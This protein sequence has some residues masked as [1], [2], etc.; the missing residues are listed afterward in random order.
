VQFFEPSQ[1]P[2]NPIMIAAAAF[3]ATP[4]AGGLRCAGTVEMGGLDRRPSR[5]PIRS[6]R[7]HVAQVFP[8][9][10]WERDEE[11]V[12][13]RPSTPDSLPLIGEIG[14]TGVHAAFGHQ[15]VGLT[16]GPRTGRWVADLIMGRRPNIDLSPYDAN[17][18][19]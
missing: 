19:G 12:G 15:H 3:V 18:F 4:M 14:R 17:R 8:D 7:S 11:W 10:T 13:F 5:G 9:L 16:G 6:I 2:R 1:V